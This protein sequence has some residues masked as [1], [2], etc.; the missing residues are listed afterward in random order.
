MCSACWQRH[1]DR[2]F[3][4]ADN[5]TARLDDPPAWLAGFVAHL[6]ARNCV[7]RTCTMITALGRLLVDGQ[8]HHPQAVLERARRPGRSMGSLAR[9]L[10]DY[11]TEHTLAVPT[12]Q[13]QRLAAGRRRRRVEQ[14]PEPLRATV[15]RFETSMLHAR[16]RARRAGTRPRTD[17][18]IE[19]ALS[20]MRDFARFLTDVR[21]KPDWAL[22]EVG[23]VETVLAL[24]PRNR[25][26]Q[27]TV[28]R[29]FF[30]F[31]RAQRMV[32][33]DPT[34]GLS[35]REPRGFHGATLTRSQQRTLFRRW[36]GEPR[37]HPHE[38]LL[39]VL[40]LLHG[41]SS[42]EVRDL[43]LDDI[44]S[45]AR[46][47]RL[48]RRP[49]PVPLDPASW[50]V[51]QRCLTHRETLRTANPHVMV[52]RG[53]KATTRPASP[54]YL[55]HLLDGCGVPPRTLRST[56]LVDLVNTLD[57]K[58]VSAAFGMN[59]QATIGYLADHVDPDRLPPAPGG[60]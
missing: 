57:P 60:P 14:T 30:R 9:A 25:R 50:A 4:Q 52:T 24:L 38:A 41:A 35:A 37:T 6:T 16:D 46:A 28:L 15:A 29:Q 31:A 34:R 43:S 47:I 18:T 54:A 11:F 26:R 21:G 51:L 19:S 33:A 59:P 27:L 53:T 39:G 5:L 2:P 56:R 22:A 55:S 12:D 3:V 40:A 45:V 44:D 7:G 49:Y 10:E 8:S 42:Q 32:L 13:A 58:I 23:D 20:T 1:P 36:T 17:H 48:G